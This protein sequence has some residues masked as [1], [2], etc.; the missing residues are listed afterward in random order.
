MNVSFADLDAFIK[1]EMG[2]KKAVIRKFFN[3]GMIG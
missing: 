3:N 2:E 1:W